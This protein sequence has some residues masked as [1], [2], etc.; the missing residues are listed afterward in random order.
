MQGETMI[1]AKPVM[2]LYPEKEMEISVKFTQ[3]EDIFCHYFDCFAFRM[4]Y[5]C[6][7]IIA[8][9]KQTKYIKHKR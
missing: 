9:C 8:K 4:S 7:I 5:L 3:N 1:A 2:Y 6:A